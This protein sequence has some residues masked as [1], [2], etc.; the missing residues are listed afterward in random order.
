MHAER[1][2]VLAAV[3]EATLARITPLAVDVG[4][5]AAAVAR[6]DVRDARPHGRHLDAQF[7]PGNPRIAEKGHL[8]EVA[9]VVG[10]TDAHGMHPYDRL[11]RARRRWLRDVD[12][13][14]CFWLF[15]QERLHQTIRSLSK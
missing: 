12:E 5:D 8:A 11:A 2:V 13:T 10:A 3:R 14:K 7:V 15:E 1:L 9:A 6:P 4:L